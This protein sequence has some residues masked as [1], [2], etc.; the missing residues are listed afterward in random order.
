MGEIIN[1][2]RGFK[3]GILEREHFPPHMW[4]PSRFTQNNTGSGSTGS[5]QVLILCIIIWQNKIIKSL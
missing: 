1:S 5:C 3:S 4:H 2:P